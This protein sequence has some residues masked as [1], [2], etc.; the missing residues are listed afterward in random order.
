M[1]IVLLASDKKKELMSDFCNAYSGILSQHNLFSTGATGEIITRTTKL[2]TI[3]FLIGNMGG[4]EQIAMRIRYN[5]IDL[6]LA[7]FDAD[8][9]R[10]SNILICDLLQACDMMNIPYSTNIGTAEMLVQGL[11]HGDLDWRQYVKNS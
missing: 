9:D 10:K 1:N 2:K 8:I 4:M 3:N 5:E 7:L 11:K 6:L